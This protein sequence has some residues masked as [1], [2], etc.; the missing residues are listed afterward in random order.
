MTIFLLEN[1][2]L[3]IIEATALIKVGSI[4][5]PPDRGGLASLTGTVMRTGGVLGI[6]SDEFDIQLDKRGA[7]IQIDVDAERTT[8]TLWS[9]AENFDYTFRLFALMLMNPAFANDKLSL[10]KVNACQDL[11][12]LPDNPQ[13]LALREFKKIF[14]QGNPRGNVPTI[15]SIQRITRNDLVAFHHMF[16]KPCHIYLGISGDFS[17]QA[18]K[19]IIQNNFSSWTADCPPLPASALPKQ[20]HQTVL[21]TLRRSLP[22]STIIAGHCAPS[23]TDPDYYA[24]QVL[25]YLIGSGGFSSRM[26]AQIR[27]VQG[28]AY[29][30]GSFYQTTPTFGMFGMYCITKSAT[31]YQAFESM[32]AITQDM[33]LTPPSASEV[34]QAKEAII[35]N[36]IFS[37]ASPRQ[38]LMQH[39][40]IEFDHLPSDFFS[41]FPDRIRS[42]KV[43]DI[44]R[45]AC[46]WLT[47]EAM[48]VFILGELEAFGAVPT[49]LA[50]LPH[51]T[52]SSDLVSE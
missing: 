12:R 43:E 51:H 33:R 3:P 40:L 34:Q 22:Q 13:Q 31:T 25:D 47:P 7:R 44:V 52:I 42:L 26:M 21:Y 16:F 39:M 8:A 6:T 41:S 28:L 35:N 38:I 15:D 14:Y 50:S 30:V 29:S 48:T 27:T 5:D 18:M 10:A 37:S 45:A 9:L 11:R 1:H 24:F 32:H 4:Y 20:P 19:L 17:A 46:T 23:K 36:F 49:S 2:E